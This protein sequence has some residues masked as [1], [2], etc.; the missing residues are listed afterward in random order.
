MSPVQGTN[1]DSAV[2]K[3]FRVQKSRGLEDHVWAM[4]VTGGQREESER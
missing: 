4:S 1:N 3:I 2:A